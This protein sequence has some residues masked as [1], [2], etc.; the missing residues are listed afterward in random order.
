MRRA[1]LA[2]LALTTACTAP[3]VFEAPPIPSNALAMLVVLVH[4]NRFEKRDLPCERDGESP[5]Y[6]VAAKPSE[7]VVVDDVRYP[8]EMETLFLYYPS[9]QA[10]SVEPPSDGP[11]LVPLTDQGNPLTETA[12]VWRRPAEEVSF[13]RYPDPEDVPDWLRKVQ[14][15]PLCR[16]TESKVVDA[17][18][19][20]LPC[21]RSN[22]DPFLMTAVNRPSPPRSV[23]LECPT[24]FTPN[25]TCTPPAAARAAECNAAA[26]QRRRWPFDGACIR[27][28]NC[29]D[30]RFPNT[31]PP[32]VYVESGGAGDGSSDQTPRGSLPDGGATTI[33]VG[34]G[35]I[36]AGVTFSTDTTMIGRCAE[37]STI[38]GDITVGPGVTVALRAVRV[39]GT[40]TVATGGT[41]ILDE[42]WLSAAGDV[43]VLDGAD[44]T[45]TNSALHGTVRLLNGASATITGGDLVGAVEVSDQA[46]LTTIASRIAGAGVQVTRATANLSSTAIDGDAVALRAS[47]ADVTLRGVAVWFVDEGL[48]IDEGTAVLEGVVVTGTSMT[49]SVGI[50]AL[51][52]A[53]VRASTVVVTDTYSG[54]R[55]DGSATLDVGDLVVV[56]DEIGLEVLDG[57]L[58]ATRANVEAGENTANS[59]Y[60]APGARA[61]LS[62]VLLTV[63]GARHVV[64]VEGDLLVT[65]GTIDGGLRGVE[66]FDETALPTLNLTDVEIYAADEGALVAAQGIVSLE[67]VALN[68]TG[69]G[70]AMTVNEMNAEVR[71]TGTDVTMVTTTAVGSAVR[72]FGGFT[73]LTGVRL[74]VPEGKIGFDASDEADFQLTDALLS[75]TASIGVSLQSQATGLLQNVRIEGAK[76]GIGIDAARLQAVDLS[77]DD[78]NV[79]IAI[80]AADL[81]LAQTVVRNT[82]QMIDDFPTKGVG[83]SRVV[84]GE[85]VF[86]FKSCEP[87]D[88]VLRVISGAKIGFVDVDECGRPDQP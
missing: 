88:D 51:G 37:T 27:L 34:Q 76:T 43:L 22:Y 45:A 15:A 66:V 80:S 19:R 10:A 67:R 74:E 32:A 23:A 11:Q 12:T 9:F 49:A 64:F 40:I 53:D 57:T 21:V 62:D 31:P 81:T 69:E 44:S 61:E 78:T 13:E 87:E 84:I 5:C 46:S 41:L 65:R 77:I 52:D 68:A 50:T 54:L 25:R 58:T 33:A 47:D 75:G 39:D 38:I 6:V 26:S 36:T 63:D 1:I 3:G 2:T 70:P 8:D 60:V 30:D 72:L 48:R 24:D 17:E 86:G 85:Q 82:N 79:G 35:P 18:G 42:A 16:D 4:E 7:V 71:L 55:T 29:D 73:S 83:M 28:G 56:A 59:V 20:A 14:L